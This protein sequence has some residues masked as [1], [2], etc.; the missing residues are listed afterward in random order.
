VT[1]ALERGGQS[2]E[3]GSERVGGFATGAIRSVGKPWPHLGQN[4]ICTVS[5]LTIATFNAPSGCDRE[6]IKNFESGAG[7]T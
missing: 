7:P 4:T 1:D 3:Q 5:A 6:A 2:A